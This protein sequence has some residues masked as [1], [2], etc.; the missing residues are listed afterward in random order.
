MSHMV[1]TLAV[2]TMAASA[3]AVVPGV[4]LTVETPGVAKAD[5][6]G[7]VGGRHASVGGCADPGQWVAPPPDDAQPQDEQTPAP[8]PAPDVQGCADVGGRHVSVGGCT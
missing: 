4:S 7:D 6:C 5:V 2:A 1:R 3:L 8:P